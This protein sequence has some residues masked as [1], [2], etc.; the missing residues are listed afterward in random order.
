MKELLTLRDSDVYDG[1]I[2]EPVTD[3]WY[4]RRAVR[5]VVL[6]ESNEVYLLKMSNN[7]YHKLP[8]GGIDE[9]ESNEVALKRELLE[10]IGCPAEIIA[11]LGEVIEY[12][13]AD[14]M[15]QH[16]YSYLV[17][18]SGDLVATALE[19]GEIEEGAETVVA[20]NI[21]DAILLLEN[22]MPTRHEGHAMRLRELRILRE[23]KALLQNA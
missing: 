23:A 14:K 3:E 8:G 5:A 20:S 12:R 15:E 4:L 21:D 9:G 6:S 2:D 7:N 11:E 18:Q 13:N 19:D 10:E 22:D 1:A 16:S 17:R